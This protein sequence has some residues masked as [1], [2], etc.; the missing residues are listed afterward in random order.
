MT[1]FLA[2]VLGM[3]FGFVLQKVGAANPQKIIN[4]LR[5]RDL[6][7]M[8]AILLGLGISSL[9]LFVLLAFGAVGGGNL[10][11]KDSYV[12]V[13][14]GG[15]ILGLGWAISGYCPGTGLVA[16]GAGRKDAWSFIL[17]GML[18]AF[19][20]TLMYAPLKDTFL[21]AKLGGKMSLANTG[22]A[23]FP[24]L[25]SSLPALVVAGVIAMAFGVIA[26]MLPEGKE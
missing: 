24:A 4:M 14:V 23:D 7:L 15:G 6:H 5:L 18:G 8:K 10:D 12:G 13:I 17:G 11:V 9:G 22:N 16:A 1:I 20:F 2:I 26:W 19:I 21:F 3:L 25:F